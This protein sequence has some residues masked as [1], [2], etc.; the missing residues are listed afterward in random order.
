MLSIDAALPKFPAFMRNA[1]CSANASMVRRSGK[2][3]AA[4]YLAELTEDVRG[5]SFS[6]SDTSLLL[7]SES[8]ALDCRLHL[9][10]RGFDF[11]CAFVELHGLTVPVSDVQEG[12][13]SRICEGVW[14]FRGLRKLRDRSR[15]HLS[16]RAGVVSKRCC[17]YVSDRLVADVMERRARSEHI[18]SQMVAYSDQGDE[19]PMVDVLSS[20]LANPR[21][22]YAE[23]MVR[24]YGF[25]KHANASDHVGVFYTVTSPSKYHA[26]R[27]SGD[28]NPKYDS[29][30]TP[31][32]TQLYLRKLWQK[33][34]AQFL[35]KQVNPYGFRVVEPHHDGTPHWHMLLFMPASQEPIITGIL[36]DYAIKED[37][38]EI[39]RDI[40]PRFTAKPIDTS[41]GSATGYIAKYISKNV[42]GSQQ[43][44]EVGQ[45]FESFRN[46]A[47]TADTAERVS[48]WASVWGL[49]QFQ[50]IGGAPVGVWRELRTVDET[51]SNEL[52]ELAR[53]AADA[54]DW[55][56]YLTLQGGASCPRKFQKIRVYAD[57]LDIETGE[58]YFNRYGETVEK[59]RGI[60]TASI[61]VITREKTWS[62]EFERGG[63]A[64]TPWSS[65]NNC[66]PSNSPPHSSTSTPIH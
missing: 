58:I 4:Q 31:R 29:T 64:V 18:L 40:S 19:L 38:Q 53:I 47:S 6:D 55:A 15:E 3:A 49:R 45:D 27:S 48:V 62:I 61:T 1:V 51:Q 20:S 33:A 22:R 5:V 34:R 63:A 37:R 39:A 66:N 7:R 59:V 54:A 32:D 50:Q 10:T 56:A 26:V 43:G 25:E 36:R 21:N 46:S 41:K 42:K 35:K 14:W 23:L 11:A 24:I 52:I 12:I 17:L 2:S 9:E 44:F 57:E 13:E 60:K 28:F 8:L 30:I 65:V 16:I